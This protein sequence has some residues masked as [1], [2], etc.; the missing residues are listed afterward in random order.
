MALINGTSGNDN[1][2]GTAGNDTI[3]GSAGSNSIDGGAGTD[4][5][6][7]SSFATGISVTFSGSTSA[8]VSKSGG[9][10]TVTNVEF[11][12]GTQSN[13]SFVGVNGIANDFIGLGG[14]NTFQG[15]GLNDTVD[16]SFDVLYGATHG[17]MVNQNENHS[18]GGIPPDTVFNSFGGTNSIAN[19]RNVTGTSFDDTIY[20][21]GNDNIL[22]A[23]AGNDTVFGFNGNDT[24]DGG[25]G[26]DTLIG[27]AGNDTLTGGAGNDRFQYNSPTDGVDTITDFLSGSDQIALSHTGLRPGEH[28]QPAGRWRGL[29]AGA[30]CG[31]D[32][33]HRA[34]Q[35][36]R[37]LLRC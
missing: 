30:N 34:L 35:P 11:V 24:L 25:A 8:T 15:N 29:R 18:Q 16:Y 23:G 2:V 26:N 27:G 7:Y 28:R 32:A 6:D 36:Q 17:I 4:T 22:T 37:V 5:L 12:V 20:G 9:T 13:N 3:F 14:N 1:L 10:D 19:V 33:P 21:G 31:L